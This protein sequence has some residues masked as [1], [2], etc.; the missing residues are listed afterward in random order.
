MDSHRQGN[1]EFG[2]S[3]WLNPDSSLKKTWTRS[4]QWG[5]EL[6]GFQSSG[7]AQDWGRHPQ[8]FKGSSLSTQSANHQSKTEGLLSGATKLPIRLKKQQIGLELRLSYA[9]LSDHFWPE[10]SLSWHMNRLHL[11]AVCTHPLSIGQRLA[12][13]MWLNYCGLRFTIDTLLEP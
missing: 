10:L 12:L 11:L 5:L 6:I 4:A 7:Q 1:Q 8:F 9:L 13:N 3:S 2:L